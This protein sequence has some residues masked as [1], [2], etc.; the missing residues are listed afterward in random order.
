MVIKRQDIIILI[1]DG[2]EVQMD[3][4]ILTIS[5]LEDMILTAGIQLSLIVSLKIIL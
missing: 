5:I 1:F 4:I 3:I 2:A